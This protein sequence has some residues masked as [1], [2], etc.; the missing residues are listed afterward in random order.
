MRIPDLQGV[1]FDADGTLFDTE[2]LSRRVWL[3]AAREWNVPAIEAHY[4]QIIGRNHD[5][6]VSLLRQVCPPG[7]PLE[8]FM[9]TCVQRSRAALKECV[10]VKE[11]AREILEFFSQKNI[12]IALATSSGAAGT[13]IKLEQ[14]GLEPY[15]QTV[16]T[17]NMVSRGKPDPE[18][19][20]TAC[21]ALNSVPARTLAVEDS[22]NG[23]LSAQAAGMPVAMVPDL[24][25]STP[26]LEALCWGRFDSLTQL[27]KHLEQVW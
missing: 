25:P 5:G 23:V 20:L 11:G 19:Y 12:P 17:G 27:Q 13:R 1:V 3:A 15:F 2:R 9:D 6:I 7:F 21:R 22:P 8:E 16:I 10:P 18:I 26:Q 14:S 24:I 4:F